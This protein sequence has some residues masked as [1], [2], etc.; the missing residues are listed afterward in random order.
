MSFNY[1]IP[2][3]ILFGYGQIK[4]LNRQRLPGKN[5]LIVTQQKL[6][7]IGIVATVTHELDKAGATYTIFTD[8]MPNP[9]HVNV[10]K[11]ALAARECGAD[12]VL[13][14]GGGSSIDAAKVIALMARNDGELWDYIGVGTG[15]GLKPQQHALPIVCVVTTAGTGTDADCW[16]VITNEDTKEK[17][18]YGVPSLFPALSIVDPEMLTSIPVDFKAYQGF[19]A[20]FHSAEGY[21]CKFANLMGDMYALTGIEAVSQNLEKVVKSDGDVEAREKVAFASTLGGFVM[22][23]GVL[24]SQHALEHALAAAHPQLP[25]GAG[26]IMLSKAYFTHFANTGQCDDRMI[27]MAQAMGKKD[28]SSA[29]DFVEALV[30]LQEAC[31]VVD[32]KMSDYGIRKENF[33]EYTANAKAT[34]PFL[35]KSDRVPLSDEDCMA[36]LEKSYR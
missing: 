6:I 1:N 28:A 3:K 17:I 18:T 36:I 33:M 25:H 23:V 4:K 9:N 5:A 20:L 13:G 16:A 29:M 12:F 26:L 24:T 34:S 35:F 7:D 31:G 21:M 27:T 14:L 11:G 32:L 2:S 30:E 22:G 8:I 19:D 15:K 10:M